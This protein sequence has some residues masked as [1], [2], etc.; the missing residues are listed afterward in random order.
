MR[1]ISLEWVKKETEKA[2]YQE[3][4]NQS[5]GKKHRSLRTWRRS[6]NIVSLF[7]CFAV[8]HLNLDSKKLQFSI[9]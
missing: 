4:R 7:G 1:Y 6:L 5:F 9:Q 2:L 8:F 3:Q